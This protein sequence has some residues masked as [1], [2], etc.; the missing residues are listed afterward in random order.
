MISAIGYIIL[1]FI[2]FERG[3]LILYLGHGV[4]AATHYVAGSFA[5]I[6]FGFFEIFNLKHSKILGIISFLTGII[7]GM[8]WVGY[9]IDFTFKILFG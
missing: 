9:L 2:P 5:F 3:K 8:V 1:A 4:A 6:F 7:Y